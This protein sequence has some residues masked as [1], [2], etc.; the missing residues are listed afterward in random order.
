MISP[1]EAAA[2]VSYLHAAGCLTIKDGQGG[3]WADYLNHEIPN[4][5]G[6]E[7]TEATRRAV[8][9]W[10]E[11][12]RSYQVDVEHVAAAMRRQ[13]KNLLDRVGD[14]FPEGL[15]DEPMLEHSW[16]AAFRDAIYQGFPRD[17][18]ER[19]AW[20]TIGRTPPALEPSTR[21]ALNLDQIGKT[22]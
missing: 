2:A 8:K 9:D 13:R 21:H 22:P 20:Q 10:A 16:Q 4:A 3:V 14:V 1:I 17:A 7:L 18:A 6:K 15:G 11:L 19:H 5:Q 12:R